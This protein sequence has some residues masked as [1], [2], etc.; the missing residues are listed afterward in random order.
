[1]SPFNVKVK[2]GQP[3][4]IVNDPPIYVLAMGESLFETT[5]LN[6][7]LPNPRFTL[8]EEKELGPIWR[9]LPSDGQSGTT[10]AQSFTWPCR[11]I[12]VALP[13]DDG[14]IQQIINEKGLRS[15]PTWKDPSCA[16]FVGDSGK[17]RHLRMERSRPLWLDAGPLS[18]CLSGS[19]K[20]WGN[21]EWAFVR[22]EVISNVLDANP[23]KDLR[24]QFYAWRTDQA[25]VYEWIRCQWQV[26]ARLGRST[27]WGASSSTNSNGRSKSLTDCVAASRRFIL[28][29]ERETRPH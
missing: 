27:V 23:D 6:L 8:S 17:I 26:P 12:K 5:I 3:K 18:F 20:R 19:V 9:S 25:K 29:R 16:V 14:F 11:F 15:L 24:I 28:G 13:D 7:P 4:T 1:V 2:T 21:K 22:P 10:P